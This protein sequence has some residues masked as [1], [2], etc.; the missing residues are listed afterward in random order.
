MKS[1]LPILTFHSVEDGGWLLSYPPYQFARLMRRLWA[2][3][4]QCVGLDEVT[5][6]IR[7]SAP[8][9]ARSF[10][11]TFDDGYQSVYTAALPVLL[12]L[13]MTATVFVATGEYPAAG[14]RFPSMA[15]RSMLSWNELRELKQAGLAIGAHTVTHAELPNLSDREIEREL[16]SSKETLEDGI[17][18]EVTSFA[19]PKG[20][21]DSRSRA[22]AS[23]FFKCACTDRFDFVHVDSDLF[24]LGRIDSYYLRNELETGLIFGRLS[25]VYVPGRRLLRA[26]R[27]A[28]FGLPEEIYKPL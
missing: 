4:W 14:D 20:R 13:Q 15:G 16:R 9:P 21:Y 5:G 2:D 18:R 11:I 10:A 6:W 8:L 22:F 24:T 17:G 28:V 27:R 26:V 7:T 12:D 25:R 3:G 23:Q 1:V 19:Y